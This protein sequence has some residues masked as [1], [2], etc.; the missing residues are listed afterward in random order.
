MITRTSTELLDG[1]MDSSDESIWREFDHRYR[2]LILSVAR[3]L[4]L[5]QMDADDIAQDTI[6]AFLQGYRQSRY[7]RNKG[8]LRDWLCGIAANKI[9]QLY[10]RKKQ[11]E[12]MIT[13]NTLGAGFWDRMEDSH[14]KDFWDEEW[15]KGILRCALETVRRE[16]NPQNYEAFELF[17]L[18]QWPAKRVAAHLQVSEDTVYQSKSRIL[19]RI[20]ELLPQIK[21]IW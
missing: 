15:E 5:S 7:D 1:L 6:T 17:A 10:R 8:R 21:E 13:D 14:L 19:K 16:V 2:P 3:R 11:Q 20:R 4:G 12:K 18:Q 9:R